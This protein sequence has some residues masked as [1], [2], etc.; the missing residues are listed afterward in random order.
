MQGSYGSLRDSGEAGEPVLRTGSPSRRMRYA[1]AG[2]TAMALCA[3]AV[4]GVLAHRGYSVWQEQT[5][6][7]PMC[8]EADCLANSVKKPPGMIDVVPRT[9]SPE[10]LDQLKAALAVEQNLEAQA[11]T[12]SCS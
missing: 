4:A 12:T 6:L 7:V 1:A 10:E 3:V 11:R 9:L 5:V 8:D 2:L